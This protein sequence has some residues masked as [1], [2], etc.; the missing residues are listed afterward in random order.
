MGLSSTGSPAPAL[1]SYS[2][3][4]NGSLAPVDGTSAGSQVADDAAES[5]ASA[6]ARSSGK[7]VTV[8]AL[9]TETSVTTAQPDGEM[10]YRE[11][12]LPVRVRQGKSWV[13]VSTA[14]ARD[15]AGML[16]P[17][18]VPGD[19]VSFSD[20][21]SGQLAVIAADGASLS[22]SWPG[23]VPVPV[24]SGSSAT[25]GDILPGVNLILS[26]TSAEAGGFSS[27]IEVMSAAAARDPRLGRL[28]LAVRAKGVT[29]REGRGGA[30]TASG[31]HVA[32]EYTAAA[33]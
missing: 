18:A 32:G 33:R 12:V 30:L 9:T 17:A 6:Q 1:P 22:L 26:A 14:L 25:Y 20:G 21:G 7:P 13:P 10:T 27:V 3:G 5:V 28:E 24:V 16:A 31:T 29:L 2:G 8:A 11:N 4:D 23:R 15:S 19:S